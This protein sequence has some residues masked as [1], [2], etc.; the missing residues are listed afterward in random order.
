MWRRS[1]VITTPGRARARRSARSST[2]TAT[3]RSRT[4]PATCRSS[5]RSAESRS[6]GS[7]A[8]RD[9]RSVRRAQLAVATLG[10]T[11]VLLVIA[12][13]YD[14]LRF[15]GLTAEPHMAFAL[16]D[17]LVIARATL[18]LVRAL[19]GQHTFLRRLP[20]LRET[21]VHGHDVRVVPG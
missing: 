5:T 3:S 12:I 14:A 9:A 16:L 7:P 11:A 2:S 6:G 8:V 19:R 15:H 18:S 20:V 4:S 1:P 17:T 13:A 10:A 21:V